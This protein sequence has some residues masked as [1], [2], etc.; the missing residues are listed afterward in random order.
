MFYFLASAGTKI[1]RPAVDA[2]VAVAAAAQQQAVLCSALATAEA[3][4]LAAAIAASNAVSKGAEAAIGAL[5]MCPD[6]KEAVLRVV[7]Q[8]REAIAKQR[9]Q[10][11]GKSFGEQ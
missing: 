3:T 9:A 11:Q 1:S 10:L 7:K 5:A 4:E 6:N 2:A 8:K